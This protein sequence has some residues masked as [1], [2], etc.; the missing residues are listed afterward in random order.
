MQQV[1]EIHHQILAS[2]SPTLQQRTAITEVGIVSACITQPALEGAMADHVLKLGCQ[3][4][5]APNQPSLQVQHA[6][7]ECQNDW[8]L[9]SM[10]ACMLYTNHN[11]VSS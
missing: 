8:P 5:L 10:R 6:A 2:G 3:R 9:I 7:A 11:Y 1:N 4:C